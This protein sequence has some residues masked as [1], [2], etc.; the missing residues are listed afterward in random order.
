MT[1]IASVPAAQARP[2]NKNAPQTKKSVNM[3][4]KIGGMTAVLLSN[5]AGV[6]L[7]TAEES[8]VATIALPE[9]SAPEISVSDVTASVPDDILSLFSDNPL[10]IGGGIALLLVPVGINLLLNAGGQG[11]K[12]SVTSAS[13][14]LEALEQSPKVILVDIRN[15]SDIKANG[16][17]D[18]SAI[19]R[20]AVQLPYTQVVK[21]EV[22]VDE[23]FGAKFAKL[24]GLDEET[25]VVLLDQDGREA[26][27][28][29]KAILATE[30]V[31]KV[32]VVQGGAEGAKGWRESGAPWKLPSKGLQLPSINLDLGN[33]PKV[34][35]TL[36]E[37]FKTSPD[38]AK[39]GLAALGLA[40]AGV[41]LFTEVEVILQL[42]GLLAT[43]QFALKLL[44]K[45][46]R[47]Q[48]LTEIRTLVK[49]KIGVDEAGNDLKKLAT[50]LLEDVP[51]AAEK[52]AEAA[53]D[54]AATKAAEAAEKVSAVASE[55][56]SEAP[57]AA[58]A[59]AEALKT[60]ETEAPKAA[61]PTH[62][63]EANGA[64]SAAAAA[65]P[66]ADE[67]VPENV[68]EAR[69]WIAAFKSRTASTNQ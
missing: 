49:D 65:P 34:I 27:A 69:E 50:V 21:G 53:A 59:P 60:E 20:R 11:S 25:R 26:S 28:A 1:C 43:G 15:K 24:G 29:A 42:V 6:R 16:S 17:P 48:T 68:K 9:V 35:D 3:F 54:K 61:E 22:T 33:L 45:D 10:L 58:A 52:A 51:A 55:V 57:V 19:K 47:E 44:F 12:V 62:A 14:A 37:D 7:A 31:E 36:A 40:G 66:A 56:T 30:T 64:A 18:L 63:S 32:Y 41:L 46:D 13:R 67:D 2:A 23:S 39:A 38:A 5:W 4:P 8:G